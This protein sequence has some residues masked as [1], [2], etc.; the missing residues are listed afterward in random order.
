LSSSERTLFVLVADAQLVVTARLAQ[1][2]VTGLFGLQAG[3]GGLQGCAFFG[4]GRGLDIELLLQL[5]V[6][7]LQ[8]FELGEQGGFL[9]LE[10]RQGQVDGLLGFL[11]QALG[12]PCHQFAEFIVDG[13]FG[14]GLPR[15]ALVQ[16]LQVAMNRGFRAGIAHFDAYCID[17]GVFAAGE[18]RQ[19]CRLN[20]CFV[21]AATSHGVSVDLV[22]WYMVCIY[23]SYHE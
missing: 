21:Y 14:D 12:K 1:P 4:K 15:F 16:F 20:D 22:L 13:R 9:L 18:D 23:I 11:F 3:V 8:R 2:G 19:A 17:A 7:C 6:G 10:L 5:V